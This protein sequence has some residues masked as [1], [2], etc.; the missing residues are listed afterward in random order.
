MRALV[1]GGTRF[2]GAAI[3]EELARRGAEVTVFSRGETNPERFA[4]LDRVRG[5]RMT[6]LDRLG[7]RRFDAVFDSCG[8]VPAAVEASAAIAGDAF[9]AFVSSA[10]VY[11]PGGGPV[12]EDAPLA[13]LDPDQPI[14]H[15][16]NYGAAKALCERA[17]RERLGDRLA[18]LRAGLIAGPGDYMDR[19]PYWV[20]RLSRPGPVLCP[21]DGRD[22]AQLIDARDLARF[23][24]DLA[25]SRTAGCFN[26]TG[27]TGG[28]ATFADLIEATTN[29]TIEPVWAAAS[30]LAER[31]VE[32]WGDMPLWL[33][34]DHEA[35]G[36]LRLD[37]GRAAD[38]GLVTRPW[39]ET[40]ADTRAWLETTGRTLP[41]ECGLP[42]DRERELLAEL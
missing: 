42:A 8:Y 38:A 37:L 2:V 24:V 23:A 14:D 5:D 22:P 36:I 21:G 32:P 26:T 40:A 34:G 41:F 12:S 17:L 15:M 33:P 1:I 20:A 27:P 11:T 9:Y 30:L 18:I 19:F 31:G 10:S 16:A 35:A 39:A 13:A 29:T 3:V 6:D 28:A 4:E 7:D 25:E